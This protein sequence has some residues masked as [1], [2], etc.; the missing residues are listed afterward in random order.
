MMKKWYYIIRATLIKSG[1]V[2]STFVMKILRGR[3]GVSH[4][5]IIIDVMYLQAFP[6]FHCL[7]FFFATVLS[8]EIGCIL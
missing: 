1:T 2:R 3:G 4:N 6:I 7:F 5:V 8:D